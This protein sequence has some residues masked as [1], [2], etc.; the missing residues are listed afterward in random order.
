M[1]II[2]Q[3]LNHSLFGHCEL[4]SARTPIGANKIFITNEKVYCLPR[5]INFRLIF[6]FDYF[7]CNHLL[8][9]PLSLSQL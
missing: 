2:L 3:N 6:D 1:Q 9:L 7:T 5:I 4:C 8:G